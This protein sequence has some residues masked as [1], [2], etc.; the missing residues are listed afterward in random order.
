VIR[1]DAP[2]LGNLDFQLHYRILSG[3][4]DPMDIL[5]ANDARLQLISN[6]GFKFH[7]P[8]RIGISPFLYVYGQHPQM[9]VRCIDFTRISDP[10][11]FFRLFLIQSFDQ[12]SAP[13]FV[14]RQ[15]SPGDD[16]D[17]FHLA[18]AVYFKIGQ[19]WRTVLEGNELRITPELDRS[20]RAVAVLQLGDQTTFQKKD[21]PNSIFRLLQEEVKLS[22]E[23]F[24]GRFFFRGQKRDQLPE[25]I[26][27]RQ[28]VITPEGKIDP[29][30]V[31]HPLGNDRW[32]PWLYLLAEYLPGNG[33]RT[34]L[35]QC[36]ERYRSSIQNTSARF[37]FVASQVLEHKMPSIKFKGKDPFISV[38]S[39]M[40]NK[41]INKRE[42]DDIGSFYAACFGFDQDCAATSERLQLWWDRY[43]L[44]VYTMWW[45]RH[46]DRHPELFFVIFRLAV[47][48]KMPWGEKMLAMCRGFTDIPL[49]ALL[50]LLIRKVNLQTDTEGSLRVA[51]G[52]SRDMN[53]IRTPVRDQSLQIAYTR[54]GSETY[55]T[56]HKNKR[57]L[58]RIDKEVVCTINKTHDRYILYPNVYPFRRKNSLVNTL[59]IGDKKKSVMVPL[60]WRKGMIQF[61][62]LRV[63]WLLKKDRFQLTLQAQEQVDQYRVNDEHVSLGRG[64]RKVIYF[65]PERISP[66]GDLTIMSANGSSIHFRQLNAKRKVRMT[67]WLYDHYGVFYPHINYRFSRRQH[68]IETDPSGQMD[69]TID[70]PPDVSEIQLQAKHIMSGFGVNKIGDQRLER[71]LRF[72]PDRQR[73]RFVVIIGPDAEMAP[74]SVQKY[75][76]SAFG[77]SP[78]I[79]RD[80]DA[81]PGTVFQGLIVRNPA[82]QMP[83]SEKVLTLDEP[84]GD[85]MGQLIRQEIYHLQG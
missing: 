33:I 40:Q 13:V 14:I 82:G 15:V 46:L 44:P 8:R 9:D 77:F 76:Q 7:L 56:V 37:A 65:Y 41:K 10:R 43:T 1:D 18:P 62:H 61:E 4:S 22:A 31:N 28:Q 19:G 39:I 27:F 26:W 2:V 81:H 45:R 6:P 5:I 12:T 66:A 42:P 55:F 70:L 25:D 32:L 29:S 78:E 20:G 34:Q 58:I 69:H 79:M 38:L 52:T 47:Q 59:L 72:D 84:L 11:S 3:R 75:F 80:A 85:A 17:T 71:F 16:S 51:P 63:R 73:E 67:G 60:V 83:V 53:V 74:E 24:P 21:D 30:V 54:F 57:R 48:Y 50:A 36:A 64:M 68:M 49:F 23:K 35:K